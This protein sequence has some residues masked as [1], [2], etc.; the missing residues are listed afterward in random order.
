MYQEVHGMALSTV[1][2]TARSKNNNQGRVRK[3]P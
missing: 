1:N 2:Y 3:T